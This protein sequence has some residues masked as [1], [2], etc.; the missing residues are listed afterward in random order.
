[1]SDNKDYKTICIKISP[2][3]HK[4][5]GILKYTTGRNIKDIVVEAI[6]EYVEKHVG[7]E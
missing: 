6:R 5:L 2:S 3:L 7:E 4:A 1:M